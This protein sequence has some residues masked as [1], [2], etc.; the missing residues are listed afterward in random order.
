M[1]DFI[2]AAK[3]P[4]VL[5]L[6]L[7]LS[8]SLLG[9]CAAMTE[10]PPE[11]AVAERAQER[12]DYL[13]AEDYAAAYEYLSPGYR[14][15]VSLADYQRKVL[16]QPTRWTAAQ[17]GR[18]ECSEDACKLKIS[19]DYTIFGAVPGASRFDSKAAYEED[20]VRL[21]GTWFHIPA[22]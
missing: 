21:D 8:A 16:T 6:V 3:R 1:T 7:L 22:N 5:P 4:G 15:G 11:A 14:S 18:S 9:G 13:L 2:R 17:V 10:K 19:V 20:W 12:I